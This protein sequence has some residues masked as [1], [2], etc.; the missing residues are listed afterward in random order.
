[1]IDEYIAEAMRG[2]VPR[3]LDEDRAWVYEIPGVQGVWSYAPTKEA[4]LEDLRG[5]LEDWIELK[6]ER[7]HPL[8]DLENI[9]TPVPA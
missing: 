1:M 6:L 7:N 3:Y 9:R 5:V 4:S 2:A 8:P